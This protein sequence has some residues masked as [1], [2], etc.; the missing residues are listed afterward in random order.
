[1]DV[2]SLLVGDA[3]IELKV[4]RASFR[5]RKIDEEEERDRERIEKNGR[6]R[7]RSGR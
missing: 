1:M 3:W 5:T 7:S 6:R 4:I 2:V